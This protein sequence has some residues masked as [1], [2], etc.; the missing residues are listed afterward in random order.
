MAAGHSRSYFASGASRQIAI[1]QQVF[2]DARSIVA[3]RRCA[4]YMPQIVRERA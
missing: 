1:R 4:A 3:L 2:E